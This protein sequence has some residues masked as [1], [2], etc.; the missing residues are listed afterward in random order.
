M[1]L[2]NDLA[3]I[4]D[5]KNFLRRRILLGI[6]VASAF[7]IRIYQLGELPAGIYWDEVAAVYAPFLHR[8]GLFDLSLRN[9]VG[10]L[11]SGTYYW[12]SISGSSIFLTRLP[13]VFFGTALVIVT[14]L[15]AKEIFSIRIAF[16]SAVLL[17]ISPWA[18]QFSRYQAFASAYVFFFVLSLLFIYKGFNAKNTK[19]RLVCYS[20]ASLFL[21]LTANIF[22]NSIIFVPLF[23]I[24]FLLIHYKSLNTAILKRTIILAV[25]FTGAITPIILDFLI[26]DQTIDR[27]VNYSTISLSDD[28]ADLVANIAGRMY[29]HI[30]PGFIVYTTPSNHNLPFQESISEIN[31]IRNAPTAQGVLN[32]YS[33]L[34]YPGIILV[35]F[36]AIWQRSRK[37]AVLLLWIVS[38]LFVS[39]MAFYDNPSATRNIVGMPV[40]IIT[41]SLIIDLILSI[42][43]KYSLRPILQITIY[44]IIIIAIGLPA[45]IFL[46]EYFSEYHIKSAK[47][48]DYGYQEITNYMTSNN[49]WEKDVYVHGGGYR[50]NMTVAFFDPIQP[51]Q[52]NIIEVSNISI[53]RPPLMTTLRLND[54]VFEQGTIQF[55]VRINEGY[56]KAVS[57]HLDLTGY[58][59]DRL[60][61]AVYAD[62]ST[63]APNN[64]L[65]MQESADQRNLDQSKINTTVAYGEWHSVKLQVDKETISF[66]YDGRFIDSLLRND[67]IYNMISLSAES[68]H[69]TFRDFIIT[70]NVGSLIVL[71][72]DKSVSIDRQEKAG[73]W[74]ID[75]GRLDG[76]IEGYSSFSIGPKSK[77]TLLITNTKQD[78]TFMRNNGIHHNLI[79]EVHYPNGDFA[80]ALYEVFP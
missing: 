26:S 68:S 29:T 6:I 9:V 25:I 60:A 61:L 31:L 58:D 54:I 17:S 1:F 35:A 59:K 38:Y 66:Y 4:H 19:T 34:V 69:I 62:S 74:E 7:I 10:Y 45:G 51:P 56:G 33:L 18:V 72:D 12:Y 30:S 43:R 42:I 24:G 52:N 49:L 48:F 80:L 27:S 28:T 50:K 65:L 63:Y 39:G 32:Y 77:D 37:Y 57:W 64:F 8:E 20:L 16:L 75:G 15:L 22:A 79:Y 53:L 78:A 67:D 40:L 44:S 36:R 55:D 47:A 46:N 14:Y 73:L 3:A 21:G 11:L 13:E 23:T 71:H 5:P 2:L 70:Q 41:I 76:K